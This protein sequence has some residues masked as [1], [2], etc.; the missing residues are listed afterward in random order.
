MHFQLRSHACRIVCRRLLPSLRHCLISEENWKG[1]PCAR[2]RYSYVW[3]QATTRDAVSASP[4]R[5]L[6]VAC[7][8][9]LRRRCPAYQSSTLIVYQLIL[10]AAYNSININ[11]SNCRLLNLNFLKFCFSRR[12]RRMLVCFTLFSFFFPSFLFVA[13]NAPVP[14]S[15]LEAYLS[16]PRLCRT[17]LFVV[18]AIVFVLSASFFLSICASSLLLLLFPVCIF[19]LF[20]AL[21]T[22]YHPS[23]MLTLLF[24]L[25][26]FALSFKQLAS[27]CHSLFPLLKLQQLSSTC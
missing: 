24:S 11:N 21:L 10:A 25:I 15:L 18:T 23:F 19:N 5:T 13:R 14:A 12:R 7:R 8:S 2:I 27:H 4:H 9:S 26:L 3:Y 20:C 17:W 16:F 1:T 6:P 22:I